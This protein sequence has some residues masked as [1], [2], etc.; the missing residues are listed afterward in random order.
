MIRWL[1]AAGFLALSIGA[2][3]SENRTEN[4]VQVTV[5]ASAMTDYMYRGV[6]LSAHR[7]AIGSEIEIR[8]GDFYLDSGIT[9]VNLPTSPPAE[10]TFK[11]GIRQKFESFELDFGATY[12][13]PNRLL[14]GAG[15]RYL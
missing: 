4:L 10:I 6:T 3:A 15:A 13:Y 14:G 12:Y 1:A 2:F 8:F 9:S 11:G 7:P 5:S